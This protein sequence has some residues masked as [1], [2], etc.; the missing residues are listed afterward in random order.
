VEGWVEKKHDGKDGFRRRM[1]CEEGW[2]QEKDG[3]RRRMGSGEGWF[4]GKDEGKDGL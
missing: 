4:D 1:S 3:L 2:V